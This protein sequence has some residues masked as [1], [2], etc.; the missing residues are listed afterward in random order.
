[1][2]N[3]RVRDL[4]LTLCLLVTLPLASTAG[5][6]HCRLG[7]IFEL[8]V[9]FDGRN[10]TL[11]GKINGQD[12]VFQ[13]DSG[14]FWSTMS[15]A[16]AARYGLRAVHSDDFE[17]TVRGV[18]G[19][20]E[21]RIAAVKELTLFGV[22]IRHVEFVVLDNGV[23]DDSAGLIGQNLL[24]F[25]E[26]EYDF[27]HGMMRF[28]RSHECNDANLAYW[29]K[30]DE[31]SSTLELNEIDAQNPHLIATAWLNDQKLRVM[32][33]TGADISLVS[34]DAAKRAGLHAGTLRRATPGRNVGRRAP[35]VQDLDRNLQDLQD[36]R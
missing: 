32:F 7:R 19:S 11:P 22:P 27:P 23:S 5:E 34:L 18:G 4:V 26:V 31:T 33:D 3:P 30:P 24:R 8:P 25:A 9:N 14:A 28:F 6:K 12:A 20:S 2:G 35:Y 10:A 1:M 29:L 17:L 21:A 13:I 16:T 15:A 36:R